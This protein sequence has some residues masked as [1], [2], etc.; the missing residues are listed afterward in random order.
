MASGEMALIFIAIGISAELGKYCGIFQASVYHKENKKTQALAY[1]GVTLCLVAVSLAGSAGALLANKNEP[2][3]EHQRLESRIAN[4]D[5]QISVELQAMKRA[6][7]VNAQT[8][9]VAPA[10]ESLNNLNSE[11]AELSEKLDSIKQPEP[12]ALGSLA[13]AIATET[14]SEIES[15]RHIIAL[16]VALLLEGLCLLF[17]VANLTTNQKVVVD[18]DFRPDLH[19]EA[20]AMTEEGDRFTVLVAAIQGRELKP[21]YE[22]IRAF[23]KISA[24]KKVK[25]IRERLL[26]EG[27]VL[28]G[29]GGCLVPV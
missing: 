6:S 3:P 13:T 10:R 26:S 4:I 24:G 14:G 9:G 25:E 17:G 7:D 11:K 1:T 21:T 2:V 8:A 20:S 23:M 27:V 29:A 22:N 15:V 18:T 5:E 16:A 28:E 19:R 12:S